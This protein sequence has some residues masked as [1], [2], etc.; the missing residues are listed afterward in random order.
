MKSRRSSRGS[1]SPPGANQEIV[2]KATIPLKIHRF[3]VLFLPAAQDGQPVNLRSKMG[4][5]P[6]ANGLVRP[7][8]GLRCYLRGVLMASL[9]VN[10]GHVASRITDSATLPINTRFNP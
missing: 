2:A 9:S 8:L 1:P 3:I 6:S 7:F 5:F 4:L 10:T